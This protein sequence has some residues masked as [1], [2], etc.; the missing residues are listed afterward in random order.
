[1]KEEMQMSKKIRKSRNKMRFANIFLATAIVELLI[2][3]EE[4][5]EKIIQM[6]V[7]SAMRGEMGGVYW[8]HYRL[9]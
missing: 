9:A 2:K 3:I 1:M 8:K 5:D 7:L 6:A 4:M